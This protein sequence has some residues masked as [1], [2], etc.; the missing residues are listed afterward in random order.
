MRRIVILC[1]A[2]VF[3]AS[4]A[5]AANE[6][7]DKPARGGEHVAVEALFSYGTLLEPT[8]QKRVIGRTVR[9]QSDVLEG[10][11]KSEITLG[12]RTYA[13][14]VPDPD[15]S[16]AGGVIDVTR[17][18]LKRTD[19]YEGRSYERVRVELKSGK[20]AWVYRQPQPLTSHSPSQSDQPETE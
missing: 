18:E 12:E 16:I 1:L 8:V 13:I 11:R 3:Y 10:Y 6:R 15:H 7:V 14:A 4:G 17:Y 2:L 19:R 9:S 20:E 5:H